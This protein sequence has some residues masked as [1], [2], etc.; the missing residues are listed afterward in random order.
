M[1]MRGRQRSRGG[2]TASGCLKSGE[3]RVENMCWK[4]EWTFFLYRRKIVLFSL[5][6]VCRRDNAQRSVLIFHCLVYASALFSVSSN[7]VVFIL[8]RVIRYPDKRRHPVNSRRAR[9]VSTPSAA[10]T[11]SPAFPV[12]RPRL[13]LVVLPHP[14]SG[15]LPGCTC[16]P[17]LLS[18]AN[19]Q[20]Q[21]AS[22]E[23]N[24]AG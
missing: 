7:N 20:T 17:P 24:S 12:S 14:L 6:T 10:A 11:P 21:S 8:T 16:A 13:Q 3:G 2:R 18:H 9:A 22:R 4:C 15:L 23:Q 5:V 19:I 1:L